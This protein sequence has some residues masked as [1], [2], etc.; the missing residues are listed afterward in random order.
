MY[1]RNLVILPAMLFLALL[2]VGCSNCGYRC[3]SRC[4]WPSGSFGIGVSPS[5]GGCGGCCAKPYDPCYPYVKNGDT[6]S[7]GD[8]WGYSDN[9]D[10]YLSDSEAAGSGSSYY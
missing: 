6:I 8:G 2:V 10:E 5:C 9:S 7:S 4:S 1:K 3:G